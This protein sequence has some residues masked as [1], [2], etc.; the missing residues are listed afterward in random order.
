MLYKYP[1]FIHHFV[2]EFE[3]S[4]VSK[5]K[6]QKKSGSGLCVPGLAVKEGKCT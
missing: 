5:A 3:E 4:E 1:Q 6:A 2:L